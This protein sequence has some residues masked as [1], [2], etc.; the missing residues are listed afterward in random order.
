MIR[1]PPRSTLFPYTTLFRSRR[2]GS[3]A[4][5]CRGLARPAAADPPALR[6]VRDPS[7]RALRAARGARRAPRLTAERRRP[8]PR[9]LWPVPR[10]RLRVFPARFACSRRAGG[11][12]HPPRGAPTCE[13]AIP[14]R[15]LGLYQNLAEIENVPALAAFSKTSLTAGFTVPVTVPPAPAIDSPDIFAP[16]ATLPV[17]PFTDAVSLNSDVVWLSW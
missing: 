14:P 5:G 11:A 6:E 17:L 10:C 12:P 4:G 1:R 9:R 13:R 2:R 8:P 16:S 7:R 15:A 3:A